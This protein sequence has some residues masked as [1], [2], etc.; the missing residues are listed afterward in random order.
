MRKL[1]TWSLLFIMALCVMIFSG[2]GGS[3]TEDESSSTDDNSDTT[4]E[5]VST[6]IA[7]ILTGSWQFDEASTY[8]GNATYESADK[9]E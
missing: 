7:D 3:Y 2:C 8:K 1:K 4:T 5:D 6:T 9:T